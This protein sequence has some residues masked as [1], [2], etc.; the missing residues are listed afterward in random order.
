[1]SRGQSEVSA[2]SLSIIAFINHLLKVIFFLETFHFTIV[3]S[4]LQLQHYYYFIFFLVA[5]F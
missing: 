3:I 5:M 4:L 2:S 1:M